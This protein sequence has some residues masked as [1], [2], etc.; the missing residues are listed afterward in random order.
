M[1]LEKQEARAKERWG[2]P[3]IWEWGVYDHKYMW[4]GPRHDEASRAND[5]TRQLLRF[6]E[7]ARWSYGDIV[8]EKTRYLAFLI[9]DNGPRPCPEKKRFVDWVSRKEQGIQREVQC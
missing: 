2:D 5:E 1:T 4:I 9:E 8:T 3:R 7:F 6:G